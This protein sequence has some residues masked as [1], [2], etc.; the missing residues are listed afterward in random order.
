MVAKRRLFLVLFTLPRLPL[1]VALLK[2]FS[3][4][5]RISC[6]DL[7]PNLD[8]LTLNILRG[9]Q[10]VGAAATIP[11]ALGILAHAFPPSRARST[12]F[13]VF[14]AGAPIGVVFGL[15][16]GAILDEKSKWVLSVY[17]RCSFLDVL[18]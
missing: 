9:L 7:I 3:S 13:S 2:V 10:G 4:G 1:G 6:C 14:A 15:I 18:S 5:Y 12:A 17:A 8:S 16:F 11:A